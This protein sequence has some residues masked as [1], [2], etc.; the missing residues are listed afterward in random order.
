MSSRA[1]LS[2]FYKFPPAGDID[3]MMITTTRIPIPR[4]RSSLDFIAPARYG[5]GKISA[6]GSMTLSEGDLGLMISADGGVSAARQMMATF[7]GMLLRCAE[8]I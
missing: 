2:S 4:Y 7:D 5:A 6:G 1:S 8:G 3:A